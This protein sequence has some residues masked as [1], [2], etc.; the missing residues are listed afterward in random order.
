MTSQPNVCIF[1]ARAC[2][3]AQPPFSPPDVGNNSVRMWPG[4][5]FIAVAALI[6]LA[7]GRVPWCT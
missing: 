6:E 5:V 3:P 2:I 7:L 1:N 4:L